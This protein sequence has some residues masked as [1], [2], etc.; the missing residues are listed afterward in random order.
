MK[1]AVVVLALVIIAGNP[2]PVFYSS[3][4]AESWQPLY[5][6]QGGA[7]YAFTTEDLIR[8][9]DNV[10]VRIRAVEAL[11]AGKEKVTTIMYDLHCRQRTFRIIEV[12]EEEEGVLSV[13]KNQSDD[14]PIRPDKHPHLEK[15]HMK[16]CD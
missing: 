12:V 9:G 5:E 16:A 10:Q 15:L 4:S 6:T 8:T 2:A 14:F 3:V 7:A 13:C 11:T 1:K